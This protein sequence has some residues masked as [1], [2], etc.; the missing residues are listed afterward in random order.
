M[1]R[2]RIAALLTLS[3]L[4][5]VAQNSPPKPFELKGDRFK[6]LK[7]EQMDPAQKKMI[8][9]LLSG[10]RGGT[11]GPFNVTLRD[12]EMGD[13]A[14]NLGAYLRYHSSL[15]PKLNEF[16][17]LITG[18]YWTSQYEFFAHRPLAIK[19]GLSEAVVNQLAE[20]KR[21]AGMQPDEAIVYDFC[22]EMLTT[23]HVSDAKF[24]AVVDKFGERGAVDLT[25]VMGYYHFVSM[26]LN[27]DRYPLPEGAKPLLK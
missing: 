6:P 15:P 21:P 2:L 12:P 1:L 17:I 8:S 13:L 22:N 16:A 7:W 10:E 24:K 23:K 20:G 26:M 9:N 27:L 14:Q 11:G 4:A 19:A 25:A 3:A 5:C 18:R